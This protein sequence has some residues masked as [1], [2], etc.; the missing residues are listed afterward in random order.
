MLHMKR[1]KD[2]LETKEFYLV[3]LVLRQKGLY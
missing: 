2:I 1:R 3:V